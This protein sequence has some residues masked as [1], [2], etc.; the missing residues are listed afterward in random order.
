MHRSPV[1]FWVVRDRNVTGKE[2]MI[3]GLIL[4]DF[5]SSH[6]TAENPFHGGYLGGAG[7]SVLSSAVCLLL[8]PVEEIFLG[9]EP[10]HG[11]RG[12]NAAAGL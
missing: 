8:S 4:F 12:E 9:A 2:L 11:V 10:S 6:C 1:I 7:T 5:R 3:L